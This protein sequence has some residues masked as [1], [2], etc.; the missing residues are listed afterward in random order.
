MIKR[1]LGVVDQAELGL[2]DKILVEQVKRT[3][4]R[5]A[6]DKEKI[7]KSWEKYIHDLSLVLIW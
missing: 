2:A 5:T 7:R 1:R 6:V 3:L 4:R